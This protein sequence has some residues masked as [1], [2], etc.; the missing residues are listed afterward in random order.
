MVRPNP[1]LSGRAGGIKEDYRR[2]KKAL[3]HRPRCL[4]K[5]YKPT[6]LRLSV[7]TLSEVKKPH[8]PPGK[9]NIGK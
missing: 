5:K 8:T 9:V 2:K 1:A 3:A 7:C 6:P 4:H